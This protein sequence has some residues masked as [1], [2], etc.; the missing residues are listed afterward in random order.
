MLIDFTVSTLG[1][2][3]KDVSVRHLSFMKIRKC[4]SG[5]FRRHCDLGVRNVDQFRVSQSASLG[6]RASFFTLLIR[7]E[8]VA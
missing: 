8:F 7:V 2:R 6:V 4:L 3:N 1:Y 5:L